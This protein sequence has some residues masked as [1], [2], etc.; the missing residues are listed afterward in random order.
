MEEAN[1]ASQMDELEVLA[2]IYGDDWK[3]VD[4]VQR[5]YNI[6]ITDG[7]DGE[8]QLS[9]QITLT[10]GYPTE[11]PPIYQ[12]SAPWLRGEERKELSAT[13]ENI[14]S[15]NI[16]ESIIYMW[17]ESVR[18]FV[19]SRLERNSE[20]INVDEMASQSQEVA[21][22]VGVSGMARGDLA[23]TTKVTEGDGATEGN[24][25]EERDWKFYA[26]KKNGEGKVPGDSC[27]VIYHGEYLHDRKSKFQGHIAAV[28]SEAEVAK[29]MEKILEDR[30]CAAA[31][32]N[33]QAYRILQ[34]PADETHTATYLTNYVDDG[35]KGGSIQMLR[36]LENMD[37]TNVIV[38]VTRWYGGIH[39]GPDRFRHINN[40]SRKLL[41]EHG[42]LQVREGKKGPKS[43]TK[44][45]KGK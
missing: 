10:P 24:E 15:E 3:V 7:S 20:A 1:L 21:D 25:E 17:V 30:R 27:P 36:L 19:I 41:E 11:A 8:L 6:D 39:L 9:L 2:S 16:G 13:L 14:Y 31:T 40:I 5:V 33:I 35:E 12:L 29:V 37:A 42:Y 43:S 26:S 32:H 44:K 22:T 18:E 4:V 23:T 28:T 38:I 34:K 45:H